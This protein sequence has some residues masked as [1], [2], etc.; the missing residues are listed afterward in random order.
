MKALFSVARW[1]LPSI[2]LLALGVSSAGAEEA[3]LLAA[4]APGYAPGM[5]IPDGKPLSLPEGARA[6]VL[7]R[8]G[9]MLELSGPFRGPIQTAEAGSSAVAA[10][11]ALIDQRVDMSAAGATRSGATRAS[12]DRRPPDRRCGRAPGDLTALDR[13]STVALQLASLGGETVILDIG[14][15]NCVPCLGRPAAYRPPGRDLDRRWGS[16]RRDGP[17]RRHRHHSDVLPDRDTAFGQ[18]L[19]VRPGDAARLR[20]AGRAGAARAR[21]NQRGAGALSL[22]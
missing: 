16:F 6:T 7:L 10:V 22:E 9:R 13:P 15:G 5:I 18:C 14:A 1:L 19:A 20:H 17:C 3:V 11:K 2:T 21:R 4:T 8:S 12:D